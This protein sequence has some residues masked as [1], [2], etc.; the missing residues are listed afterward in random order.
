MNNVQQLPFRLPLQ[1]NGA[2]ILGV[3]C[4]MILPDLEIQP[5]PL[6]RYFTITEVANILD[7]S[8]RSVYN[9]TRKGKLKSSKFGR[10]IFY[11]RCALIKSIIIFNL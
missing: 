11:E 5:R 1:H 8:L 7:L 2:I 6:K 3:D 4:E 9:L 10:R